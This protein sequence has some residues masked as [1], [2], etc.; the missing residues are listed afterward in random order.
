MKFNVKSFL[1][2]A[3][4]IAIFLALVV[5][6][7]QPVT[8]GYK[9]KQYD[10]TT[11]KGTSKEIRDFR[12]KYGEEPLWTNTVFGGMP[13]TLIS[14]QYN[15]NWMNHI[16]R[17]M[18]LWL[19][20]PLNIIFVC[21]LGFYILFLCLKVDPWLAIVGAIAFGFSTYNFLIIEAGHNT[22]ALAMAWMAPTLGAIIYTYRNKSIWGATM[23]MLFMALELRSNHLQ[24]TYYL[25]LIVLFYG[26]FEFVQ[27]LMR[28]ELKKFFIRTAFVLG[29]IVLAVLPNY[30]MLKSILEVAGE[31]TRAES[32]LTITADGKSNKED[33]T[34]GLN[35][36]YI[37]DY[38]YGKM[39]SFNLFIPNAVGVNEA[40]GNYEDVMADIENP[41]IAQQVSQSS[42]YWS[43]ESNGGP[44]YIGAVAVTLFVLSF[45]FINDLT[46]WGFLLVGILA[47]LLAWGKN[48]PGLTDFFIDNVPG[49][50]KF[51]A[52]TIILVVLQV[53]IPLLGVWGLHY[54][55]KNQEAIKKN[56]KRFYIVAGAFLAFTVLFMLIGSS[57]FDFLTAREKQMFA[58]TA[59]K[60]G[61]NVQQMQ[62]VNEIKKELINSRASIFSSD[63]LRTLAFVFG[64]LLFV[65]LFITNIVN[66]YVL[67]GAMGFLVLIDLWTVDIRFL[68]NEEAP[69]GQGYL[70][71]VLPEEQAM[72]HYA[73]DADYVIFE[74]EIRKQ[75]QLLQSISQ[76]E[77]SFQKQKD[78]DGAENTALT[79]QE[80]D[81]IRFRELNFATS[82]RVLNLENPFNDG[83][84]CYFHKSIG[85]YTGA[86]QKRIQ[87]IVEFHYS[88]EMQLLNPAFQTNNFDTIRYA[89]SKLNVLNMMNAKY[90]ILSA[91]GKGSI[92]VGP[93]TIIRPTEQ[94][95]VIINNFAFGNAWFVKNIKQVKN[96]DEEILA[97]NNPELRSTAIMQA[98]MIAKINASAGSGEGSIELKSYKP[99]KLVYEI[100]SKT[101]NLALFSEIFTQK[102]W[103]AKLDGKE[104]PIARANYLIRAVSVPAG[105]HSLEFKFDLPAY[106][107]GE[108]ISLIGSIL[109]FAILIFGLFNF[110]KSSKNE[111]ETIVPNKGK[112]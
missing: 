53:I 39:E 74:T 72:P 60:S 8:E 102:G 52:V 82:Y 112:A 67:Y 99:N 51:R 93:D 111:V 42:A 86:K 61:S 94:P 79:L 59:L 1:P 85:G 18:E 15:N 96:D 6:Y 104:V 34:S 110:F 54:L 78:A 7:F 21:M 14:V 101:N 87:E 81:N 19:P 30:S 4:A 65:Y 109:V 62:Y 56:I 26:I 70:S 13:A 24:V 108:K 50:N 32:K 2:H 83:R 55:V 64:C 40:L 91:K 23:V 48:S 37:V 44:N 84:T 57:S 97:L 75:P 89:I 11:F 27:F 41:Q 90:I 100:D 66:K 92:S 17:A 73:N 47:L 12:E 107:S 35:R 5:I 29:G 63:S 106:R 45:L 58:D 9:L 103:S 22:K 98:D 25:M 77:N 76:L 49:Y 46:K 88:K 10:N 16:E 3:V 68:N 95:S 20:H 28:K 69:S 38:S 36:S 71:W 33:K 105:K 43:D 31:T 80:S